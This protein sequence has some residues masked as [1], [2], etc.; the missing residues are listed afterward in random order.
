MIETDDVAMASTDVDL[1]AAGSLRLVAM[2]A[3]LAGRAQLSEALSRQAGTDMY[4][5]T[6]EGGRVTLPVTVTGPLERLSV[7][8]D[9]GDMA[10]RAMRNRAIEE[11]RKAIERNI[12]GFGDLFK[13]PPR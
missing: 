12:P 5:Y 11:A 6:Q 7:R 1:S 10:L 2:A 9:V 4:R 3:D 8:V 13:R